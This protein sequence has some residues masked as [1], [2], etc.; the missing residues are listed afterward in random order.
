MTT[1][2]DSPMLRGAELAADVLARGHRVR[3]TVAGDSMRPS[4]RSGDRVELAPVREH[5]LRRGDIV[6]ITTSRGGYALHRVLR[7]WGAPWHRVQTRGDDGWRL[8]DAV[9][10]DRV[11]GVLVGIERN[12]RE[13]PIESTLTRRVRALIGLAHSGLRYKGRTTGA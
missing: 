8:D 3:L 10:T 13:R 6:L 7:G 2:E 4:V 12:G 11:H 9:T 5:T 1:P